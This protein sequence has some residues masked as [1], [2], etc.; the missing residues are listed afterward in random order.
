MR[1]QYYSESQRL[2]M[3]SD[4]DDHDLDQDRRRA[5]PGT[6]GPGWAQGPAVRLLRPSDTDS[7]RVGPGLAGDSLRT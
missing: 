1:H 7:A 6:P 4:S 2:A 5:P 3:P